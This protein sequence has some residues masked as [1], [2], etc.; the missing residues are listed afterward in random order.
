[1][2]TSL[3]DF[4]R[5]TD[6]QVTA[7]NERQA[8]LR[9]DFHSRVRMPAA[10]EEMARASILAEDLKRA[11]LQSTDESDRNEIADRLAE[12]LAAQG[13]FEE[14]LQYVRDDALREFYQKAL[15]AVLSPEECTCDRVERIIDGQTK[16]LLPKYRVIKQIYNINLDRFGYLIECN[17][18]GRWT[19]SPDNPLP[20]EIRPEEF[21]PVKTPND[22][23]R[24]AIK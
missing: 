23:Q 11:F 20:A 1:M 4:L 24:L 12:N 2:E 18:C 19:F 14:A 9:R 5:L 6:E 22:I 7:E 10:E 15:V 13:R 3:P 8:R 17:N 21:D 16:V